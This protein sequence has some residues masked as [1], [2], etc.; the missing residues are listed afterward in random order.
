M[1]EPNLHC[2]SFVEE[3]ILKVGVR[4]AVSFEMPICLN[5]ANVC[6]S[7]YQPVNRA[8]QLLKGNVCVVWRGLQTVSCLSE[9]ARGGDD[10][11]EFWNGI[12]TPWALVSLLFL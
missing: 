2:P 4:R 8:S 3:V 9:I 11:V 1:H 5:W 10:V 6:V 12:S 7:W